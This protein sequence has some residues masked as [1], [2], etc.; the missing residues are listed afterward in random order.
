MLIE[1]CGDVTWDRDRWP[2]FQAHEF[3]CNHCGEMWWDE[4]Y[5]DAAQLIR[6]ALGS[7]VTITSAHRCWFHNALVGGAP[8][9]EHKKIALDIAIA[10]HD[11]TA[12]LEAARLAG[13]RSFGFYGTFLHVDMRDGRVWA[14]KSGRR[15]WG[16]LLT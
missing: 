12:L 13:F 9:S 10:Q 8:A 1:H 16:S 14:T 3:A 15:A 7:P 4:R 2:N 6:E 5:F 11:K